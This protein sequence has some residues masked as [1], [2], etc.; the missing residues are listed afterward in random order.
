MGSNLSHLQRLM[1]AC[2]FFQRALLHSWQQCWEMTEDDV[3]FLGTSRALSSYPSQPSKQRSLWSKTALLLKLDASLLKSKWNISSIGCAAVVFWFCTEQDWSVAQYSPVPQSLL[4]WVVLFI[5]CLLNGC[6]GNIQLLVT[7]FWDGLF[8]VRL[9][10][11][12]RE[13]SG[14]SQFG[15]NHRLSPVF[16]LILCSELLCV[17]Y[18]PDLDHVTLLLSFLTNYK[19]W[20]SFVLSILSTLN[21]SVRPHTLNLIISGK[22]L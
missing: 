4:F 11:K 12:C 19:T 2:L 17:R 6:C 22:E 1:T 5:F 21:C 7:R 18:L 9:P 10:L 13:S 14:E 20:C 16:V 8:W 3:W 15:L